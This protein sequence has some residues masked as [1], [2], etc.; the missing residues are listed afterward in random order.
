MSCLS[1]V[2]SQTYND[3]RKRNENSDDDNGLQRQVSLSNRERYLTPEERVPLYCG[4]MSGIKSF[5]F[6]KRC[7]D[8][9][10]MNN[11]ATVS[12]RIFVAESGPKGDVSL[13]LKRGRIT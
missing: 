11:P 6:S 7:D 8:A 13:Q 12:D 3:E 10:A 4:G 2:Y 9:P 1:V 5:R